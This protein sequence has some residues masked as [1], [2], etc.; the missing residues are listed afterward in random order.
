[1]GAAASEADPPPPPGA[2]GPHIRL[3]DAPGPG[4]QRFGLTGEGASEW[5]VNIND[6][7]AFPSRQSYFQISICPLSRSGDVSFQ[8]R[9][10]P[11]LYPSFSSFR[12]PKF[13]EK[14]N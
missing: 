1:M 13:K 2:L 7:P 10:M 6:D 12:A 8:I 9:F 4:T 14:G 3:A 5:A 11:A